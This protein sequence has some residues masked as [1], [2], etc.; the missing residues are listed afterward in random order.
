[1]GFGKF[2]YKTKREIINK[3]TKNQLKELVYQFD[4]N[5]TNSRKD[6]YVNAIEK[7][8]KISKSFLILLLKTDGSTIN[9]KIKNLRNN[10]YNEFIK[11]KN[12]SIQECYNFITQLVVIGL[13][14]NSS[15]ENRLRLFLDM[16]ED[17]SAE[18]LPKELKNPKIITKRMYN[19]YYR[20]RNHARSLHF[21]LDNID[22]H[23]QEENIPKKYLELQNVENDK[24][25]YYLAEVI[26]CYAMHCYDAIVVMLARATEYALKDYLKRKK[27]NVERKILGELIKEFQKHFEDRKHKRIL[28]KIL[29]VVNLDRIV[30]A[31]D[32]KGDR[33]FITRKEADHIW[34]AIQ[35]I[36]K[37]LLN[38]HYEFIKSY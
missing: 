6:D 27:I 19:A 3:F 22:T 13:I 21:I 11:N 36:L 1:M 28:N 4:I 8:T 12:Q 5:V 26:K 25:R 30:A 31:H 33:H 16:L 23:I 9:K 32:I 20:A 34:T 37:N 2:R 15:L 14:S 38:I 10:F 17:I 7:T 18:E 24:I 29:E 35:I